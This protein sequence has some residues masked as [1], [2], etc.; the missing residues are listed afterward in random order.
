MGGWVHSPEKAGVDAGVLAGGPPLGLTA[1]NDADALLALKPDCVC[2]AASG[3]GGDDAAMLDYLRFLNAGIKVATVTATPP[4]LRIPHRFRHEKRATS[5]RPRPCAE[6]LVYASGIEPG[7]AADQ[8]V[9]TMLTMSN[10]IRSVR[11]QE[12]FSYDGYPVEFMMRE[13][14]GFG[15]PMDHVPLMSYGG[16]QSGT[17]GPP[18]RMIAD[19]LGVTLDEIRE[20]LTSGPSPRVGSRS[21]AV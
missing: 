19:A 15:Q 8:F 13:V 18:V 3:P 9:L 6:G 14:F 17:W 20:L 5:W 16:A 12:L 2:Y 21:P 11:I 10:T 1:T 7:F 4:G